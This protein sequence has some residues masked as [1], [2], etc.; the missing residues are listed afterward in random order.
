MELPASLGEIQHLYHLL[1]LVSEEGEKVELRFLSFFFLFSKNLECQV[2]EFLPVDLP[3]SKI[4]LPAF[5]LP[6]TDS[7]FS[8][9]LTEKRL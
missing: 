5:L 7:F 6:V 1:G 3:G 8:L 9:V 2:E 4:V